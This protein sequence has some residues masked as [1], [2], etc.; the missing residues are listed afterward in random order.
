MSARRKTAAQ[1]GPRRGGK[2]Q[3]KAA[4]FQA[5]DYFASPLDAITLPQVRAAYERDRMARGLLGLPANTWEA[6]S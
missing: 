2:T 5:Q 3:M 6:L 1:A 4:N